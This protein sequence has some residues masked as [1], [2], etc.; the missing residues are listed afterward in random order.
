M[1]TAQLGNTGISCS[2]LGFGCSSILGRS[3][4]R[5]SL[6]ALG[7]AWDS[8]IT[9]YDTARSYGF[10]ESEAVLGEFL[11]GRRHQAVISTK[12]GILPVRPP[13]WKRIA[14]PAARAIVGLAPFLRGTVRKQA[15][16]QST[17]SNFSIEELESSVEAS[18][19]KLKTDYLDLLFLHSP[20]VS[21]LK[22]NDL[23]AAMEKLV[24]A[25][26]V[27]A[28][29]ISG[30]SEVV[31][32]TT[33]RRP[34]PLW[35]LQFPCN[36]LD[37]SVAGVI[38]SNCKAFPGAARFGAIANQPFGGALRIQECRKI[39]LRVAQTPELNRDLR[40]KLGSIDDGVLSDVVLNTILNLDSVDAVVTS[41]M[42]LPHL[43]KNV[44]AVTGSRFTVHD[45]REIADRIHAA[46]H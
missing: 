34:A 41:M 37:S 39:L 27:R 30:D 23:L 42:R 43:E 18:L 8:G 6:R 40:E 24:A 7:A 21:I 22:Q 33:A 28:A 10:G 45:L 44:A 19:R 29:G 46:A 35:A 9:L 25:G 16:Q 31:R 38:E 12:F 2:V 5:E 4:K 15:G 20:P 1:R 14:K 11:S 26:K 13:L 3:G 17:E 36:M 32:E